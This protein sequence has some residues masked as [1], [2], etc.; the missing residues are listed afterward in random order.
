MIWAAACAPAH[1]RLPAGDPPDYWPT[2]GWQS[3]T[4]EAQGMDSAPLADMLEEI[5]TRG[6]NIHSVLVIRNGYMVTEAYFHP[7][8]RDTKIHVQSVTKS[9]ISM[10]VGRAIEDGYIKSV[11]EKLLDLYQDRAVQ[12]DR[13]AKDAIR[14]KHL[15][16]MSSGL[17]CSN[18]FSS[19]PHMEQSPDWVQ[20][21]LDTPMA[22]E[23]GRVFGYCNENAHLLAA[24]LER[25]SGLSA[26]AYANQKLFEPLGI[27]R[28]DEVDWAGDPQRIT[29]GG[30]GLHLRPIDMAR[31]G[32]LY[33]NQGQWDGQQ[34]I[35]AEWVAESTTQ[36]IQKDDGDGY[37]YLWT[38]YPD[39]DHYAALGLGGQQIHIYPSRNLLVVVTAALESFAGT[40][41]ID[42]LLNDYILPSIQSDDPLAEDPAALSRL[43]ENLARAAHPVQPVLPLPATAL[44]ISDNIYTFETNPMGWTNIQF[45][46]EEGAPTAQLSLQD[47][48]MLEV[49][50]DNLYRHSTGEEG[51]DLLLRG[52][53]VDEQTFIVE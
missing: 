7:Y 30:F 16:S 35:P 45:F 37:G 8:Q 49:G 12:E 15:L 33:L 23:P 53:W 52:R 14:L 17:A 4:P 27:P 24:I 50:L 46:F 3:S 13:E 6:T 47:W 10:L 40:P 22:D 2:E 38:V 44:D 42:A 18:P 19:G 31:L 32:F 21:V 9:V 34:I 36:H 1:S 26:R 41:D 11:E 28:V 5:A 51:E 25:A 43:Q 20:F 39:S 48:P 29:N